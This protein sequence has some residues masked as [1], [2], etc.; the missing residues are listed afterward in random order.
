[1]AEE[2]DDRA[3]GGE[4]GEGGGQ[5]MRRRVEAEGAG[6]TEFIIYLYIDNLNIRNSFFFT[7]KKVHNGKVAI[8]LLKLTELN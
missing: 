6:G 2:E 3:G 1:M 8:F 5:R 4:R 7:L